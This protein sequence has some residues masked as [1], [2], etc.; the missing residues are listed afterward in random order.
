MSG[1]RGSSW[2]CSDRTARQVDAA[3][4]AVSGRCR[5]QG[6]VSV[7]GAPRDAQTSGIGYLP[8]RRVFDSGTRVRGI[9]LVRLGLDGDRWGVPL[10]RW[11]AGR[12][13]ARRRAER[14]R[15]AEAIE[16]VGAGAYAHRPI[17]ELLRRGAA[18]AA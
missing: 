8:Q 3:A 18:A 15:V 14:E 11:V 6:R 4:G 13:R 5:L 16:Q 9:D 2:R 7:L 1:A 17:G 12:V 10:R